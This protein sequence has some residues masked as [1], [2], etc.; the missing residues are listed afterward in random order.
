M[1]ESIKFIRENIP[2][3]ATLVVGVS[4]GP[5]SMCLLNLLLEIKEEKRFN[6]VVA[7]INH[8]LREE[9]DEEYEFVKKFSEDHNLLFEGIKLGDYD[10]NS[11]E[12]EART[13]R[14]NFE[15]LFKGVKKFFYS[16]IDM[17]SY[18]VPVNFEQI[19]RIIEDDFIDHNK[20]E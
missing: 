6:I 11:I 16:I 13:K 5:D 18:K 15:E 2:N 8:N 20:E 7:H 17:N 10:T 19:E 1:D 14:Y 4:G 12:N 9:S 3:N